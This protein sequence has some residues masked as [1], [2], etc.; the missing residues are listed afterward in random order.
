MT[1][2]EVAET[3]LN[4]NISDARNEIIS[5]VTPRRD[6]RTALLV[7]DVVNELGGTPDAIARL[8]RCL[9]GP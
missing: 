7:L 6:L 3:L 8:R 9:E 1:A 2:Y 5:P 4:G